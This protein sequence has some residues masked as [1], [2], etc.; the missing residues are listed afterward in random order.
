MNLV[1]GLDFDGTVVKHKYPRL[2]E[3]I[4]AFPWLR[5]FVE[6]GVLIVLN[7]MRDGKSLEK[8]RDFIED[9][10]VP[11]YGVNNNP[12]QKRWTLSPKVYAHL[13]IDDAALGIPLIKPENERPYVDWEKVGPMVLKWIEEK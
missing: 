2:G 5:Q 13:Y 6:S 7:T 1:I 12:D 4:G 10:G 8:A 3:D 9:N 11:L